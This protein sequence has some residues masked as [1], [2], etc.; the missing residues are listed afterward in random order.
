MLEGHLFLT[1][2]FGC[3]LGL[4]NCSWTG[5][6]GL[7]LND[8]CA[9]RAGCR[10]GFFL[11]QRLLVGV[12]DVL[13][14]SRGSFSDSLPGDSAMRFGENGVVAI[15]R[16]LNDRELARVICTAPRSDTKAPWSKA[17]WPPNGWPVPEEP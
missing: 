11:P 2:F 6:L 4:G 16:S 13:V 9:A 8:R 5:R 12:V 14:V 10:T 3:D 15:F 17:V 1:G 7:A